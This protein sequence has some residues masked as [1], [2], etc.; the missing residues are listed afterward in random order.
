MEANDQKAD[1]HF[2][3]WADG[4]NGADP[5]NFLTD[6]KMNPFHPRQLT[7]L[8]AHGVDSRAIGDSM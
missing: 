3:E 6:L 8:Y 2:G 1:H 5:A 7:G 4:N